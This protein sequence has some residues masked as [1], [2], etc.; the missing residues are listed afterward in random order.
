[1]EMETPRGWHALAATARP[2][3]LRRLDWQ[4]LCARLAAAQQLRR[5]FAHAPPGRRGSFDPASARKASL[6][7]EPAIRVNLANS[8]SGIRRTEMSEV[9]WQ[10]QAD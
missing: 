8:A 9:A 7:S 4:V 10:P 3:G 1:M 2:G 5:A 6:R